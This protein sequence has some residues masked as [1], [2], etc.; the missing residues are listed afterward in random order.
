MKSRVVFAFCCIGFCFFTSCWKHCL[1][2]PKHL[3]DYFPYKKDD[4]LSFVNQHNDTLL[5]LMSSFS[6]SKEHRGST[7]GKCACDPPALI[8]DAIDVDKKWA[9][10]IRG[11]IYI[12]SDKSTIMSDFWGSK[13]TYYEKTD[14]N[15]FDSKNSAFFGETV[16]IENN[17][18]QISRVTIVKGKGITNFYDQESDFQWESIKNN[19]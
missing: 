11:E 5:F 6:V 17:Y 7:C 16:I 9:K 3:I 4:T 13:L 8:F 19:H 10:R 18:G 1:G 12:W 2:F 15:P 14:K